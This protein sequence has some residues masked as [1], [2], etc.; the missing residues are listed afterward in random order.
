MTHTGMRTKMPRAMKGDYDYANALFKQ[1][2]PMQFPWE[3][4]GASIDPESQSLLKDRTHPTFGKTLATE[5]A[6]G[7][8]VGP[9]RGRDRSISTQYDNLSGRANMP[10]FEQMMQD[11]EMAGMI[12]QLMQKKKKVTLQDLLQG[13]GSHQDLAKAHPQIEQMMKNNS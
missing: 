2:R 3:T 5:A 8:A 12:Q 7:N 6:L 1:F 13:G 10:G 4:H 9:F 11:P